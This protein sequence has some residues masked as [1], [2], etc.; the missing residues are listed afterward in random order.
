MHG[1]GK[2]VA[3]IHID[4]VET[5]FAGIHR[6]LA[7]PASEGSNIILV[8]GASGRGKYAVDGTRRWRQGDLARLQVGHPVPVVNELDPGE[9]AMGM[10]EVRGSLEHGNVLV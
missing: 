3:R 8:H 1:D 9:A 6:G 7:V 2:V 10:N 5:G 4:E